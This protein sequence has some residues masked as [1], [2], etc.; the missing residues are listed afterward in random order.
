MEP[1]TR[2][3]FLQWLQTQY[4]IRNNNSPQYES[5]IY[6]DRPN[7]LY[8]WKNIQPLAVKYKYSVKFKDDFI[9]VSVYIGLWNDYKIYKFKLN[10]LYLRPEELY[11]LMVNYEPAEKERI[12]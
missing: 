3:V 11:E 5:M 4:T 6:H 1:L 2:D 9:V 12:K 10:I 8:V 7:L